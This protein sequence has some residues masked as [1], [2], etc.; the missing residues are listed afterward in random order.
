MA[1]SVE[2]E[3]TQVAT[4]PKPKN[5]TLLR[6]ASRR[7][8]LK[9]SLSTIALLTLPTGL[10]Y[11]ADAEGDAIEIEK[12]AKTIEINSLAIPDNYRE[13]YIASKKDE[14]NVEKR[15]HR[16]LGLLTVGV[17]SIIGRLFLSD[18][19]QKVTSESVEPL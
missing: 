14:K 3:P 11:A 8:V 9:G 1:H 12:R 7:E 19:E 15:I 17:S 10:M 5:L 4:D 6:K 18:Q 13:I 2:F 16:S